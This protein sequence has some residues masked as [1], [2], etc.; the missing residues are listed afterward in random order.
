MTGNVVSEHVW[1][2]EVDLPPVRFRAPIELF[3]K[4][5]GYAV[6]WQGEELLGDRDLDGQHREFS[7]RIRTGGTR[8]TVVECRLAFIGEPTA[9]RTQEVY[10]PSELVGLLG[11]A[12]ARGFGPPVP[13]S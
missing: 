1:R 8:A 12:L 3:W 11:Q 4:G 2:W 6:R 7:V 13:T 10:A 5:L 9:R